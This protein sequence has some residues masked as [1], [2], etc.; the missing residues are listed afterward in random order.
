M[1]AHAPDRHRRRVG[2]VG[3]GA[4]SAR[5]SRSRPGD[6]VDRKDDPLRE[7]ATCCRPDRWPSRRCG[8]RPRSETGKRHVESGVAGAVRRDLRGAEVDLAL[9]ELAREVATGGVR[10]EVQ[11]EGR[12]RRAVE[13]PDD[14]RAA[15][16][17]RAQML[18]RLD[19]REVLEV[20]EPRIA[21][22]GSF[23]SAPT[24]E[25]VDPE[26]PVVVDRVAADGVAGAGIGTPTTPRM[27][28]KGDDVGL[29]GR[30]AA[31][32]VVVWRSRRARQSPRR[33]GCRADSGRRA[34]CR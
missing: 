5:A 28:V 16:P 29:T 10:I 25:P 11:V 20:V 1:S 22:A 9:D 34:A 33:A 18:D 30:R 3:A 13:L 27:V 32:R 21:V 26:L 24:G 14:P 31:D 19:D 15:R 8:R 17:L 12:R 23:A 2:E 7:L 6:G 4:L